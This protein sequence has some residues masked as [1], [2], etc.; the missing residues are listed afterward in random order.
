MTTTQN[1]INLPTEIYSIIGEYANVELHQKYIKTKDVVRLKKVTYECQICSKINRFNQMK[2]FNEYHGYIEDTCKNALHCEKYAN[3][4]GEDWMEVM[5]EYVNGFLEECK[6]IHF[7][8]RDYKEVIKQ[9]AI[10][11]KNT[12]FQWKD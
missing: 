8:G 10:D 3:K 12:E 6:G 1:I 2:H 5:A 9:R 7:F 4:Q 11:R